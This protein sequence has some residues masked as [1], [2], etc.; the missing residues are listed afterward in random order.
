M[1]PGQ[2]LQI[3]YAGKQ[4]R[5]GPSGWTMNKDQGYPRD[6]G[7]FA[8]NLYDEPYV[9]S[10]GTFWFVFIGSDNCEKLIHEEY[11]DVV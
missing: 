6:D 10:S 8:I 9:T 1:K 3:A 11:L 2:L 4:I 7:K 5:P